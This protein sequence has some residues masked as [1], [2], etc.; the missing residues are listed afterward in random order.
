MGTVFATPRFTCIWGAQ[1]LPGFWGY[2]RTQI[3]VK[4][5]KTQ[6]MTN[7]PVLPP[8]LFCAVTLV[9]D[10]LGWAL[11]GP[12]NLVSAMR[13]LG[14]SLS[15]ALERPGKALGAPSEDLQ[16][17]HTTSQQRCDQ[18]SE[19]LKSRFSECPLRNS[20][21]RATT[22][23]PQTTQNALALIFFSFLF[24]ISLLSPFQRNSLRF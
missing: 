15:G 23:G 19:T 9:I 21:P 1:V 16:G 5:G 3:T 22:L 20:N 8:H 2:S 24:W 12:L 10:S 17:P 11:S 7:R 13:G 14:H 4:H 18:V 6:K